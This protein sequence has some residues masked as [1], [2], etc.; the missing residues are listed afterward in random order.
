MRQ[1]DELTEFA[2]EMRKQPTAAER[3]L[4]NEVR[5]RRLGG[6]KFKRQVPIGPYIVDFVC[7]EAQVIVELDGR[8]HDAQQDYDLRRK[9]T[10]EARG[11]KVMRIGTEV[12]VADGCEVPHL[13]LTACQARR[14][15]PSPQPSPSGRGGPEAGR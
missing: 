1:P 3:W 2:R 11:Y 15:E 6:L 14:A 13:I 8:G 4:W 12:K 5:G 7:E 10:L 9:R